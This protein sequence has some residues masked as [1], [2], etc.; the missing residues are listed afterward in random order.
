MIG[1]G[2]FTTSGF[3]LADLH[4]PALVLAAWLA[5]GL[6]AMLGAFCYGALARHFPESGGEYLFLGKTLHPAAGYVAGWVSLLVGFSAPLAAVALAFG[7]YTR[8]WLPFSTPQL[9]GSFLLLSFAGLHATHVRRGAWVQNLAV[10]AKL[11]LIAILLVSAAAR[12]KA[13]P[14]SPQAVSSLASFAVALVWISFSYSGWNAAVYVASEIREPERN[15]PRAMILGAAV[16]TLI[17]LGLNTVFVYAAPV[18][19]LAGRLEIGQIAARALGGSGLANLVTALIA[20]ALATSVSS[21]MMAGPRVFARMADD[22]CLPRWF[23]FP[24]QGPPRS[25]ILWQTVLALAMLWSA[26]FKG[27]LTYIGFTLGLCTAG[28]VA[29]LIRL[30]LREGSQLHVPGWPWAPLVFVI[31]VMAITGFTMARRP[32][33]SAVGLGTLLLGWLAWHLGPGRR[34]PVGLS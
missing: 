7:E 28:A 20:L 21:M 31:S 23:R 13:P 30:R 22:A 24:E 11:L 6:L 12:L 19:E 1:S 5:G 4:R 2:V 16:V 17:Y 32:G 26:T 15:L 34:A 9:T 18:E 10:L 33:E 14:T 25:A 29:G 3:L 8:L 27:L